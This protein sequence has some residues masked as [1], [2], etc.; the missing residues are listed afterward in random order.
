MVA[1]PLTNLSL[2]ISVIEPK[3]LLRVVIVAIPLTNLSLV[4]LVTIPVTIYAL[5]ALR[6]VKSELV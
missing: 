3:V 4:I 2:L 5:S 1:I 6:L